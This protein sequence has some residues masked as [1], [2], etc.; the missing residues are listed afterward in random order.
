MY[1]Y[2]LVSRSLSLSIHICISLSLYICMYTHTYMAMPFDR[3][4]LAGKPANKR[5]H[6]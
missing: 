5:V 1:T 3:A 4:Q 6:W 2:I